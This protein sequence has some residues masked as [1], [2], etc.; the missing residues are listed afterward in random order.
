[1]KGLHFVWDIGKQGNN[2]TFHRIHL[3]LS[4]IMAHFFHEFLHCVFGDDDTEIFHVSEMRIGMNEF[5]H[6]IVSLLKQQQ[7]GPEKF[8]AE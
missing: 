1:M 7:E 3:K 5:D 6:L 8:R 2:N 4:Y